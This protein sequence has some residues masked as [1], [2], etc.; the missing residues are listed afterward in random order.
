MYTRASRS[1]YNMNRQV[2]ELTVRAPS[3]ID[4]L[5]WPID[6]SACASISLVDCFR[7]RLPLT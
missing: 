5:D 7:R 4:T 1:F 3:P 2:V 6:G